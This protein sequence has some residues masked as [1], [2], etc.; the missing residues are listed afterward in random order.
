MTCVLRKKNAS[1][2]RCPG[3]PQHASPSPR[4]EELHPL[5]QSQ[6]KARCKSY[7]SLALSALGSSLVQVLHAMLKTGGALQSRSL[8][9]RAEERQGVLHADCDTLKTRP[10]I[11]EARPDGYLEA[12]GES[13]PV[14]S[15]TTASSAQSSPWTRGAPS[16]WASALPFGPNGPRTTST[17]L[18]NAQSMG[19]TRHR[20]ASNR[21]CADSPS[22][23]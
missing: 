8:D 3:V 17:Q 4:A 7:H 1:N 19:R 6:A 12:G 11:S 5:A 16:T 18:V 9:C 14:Q 13:L 23:R 15:S 22:A 2:N 21:D 20:S 10:S